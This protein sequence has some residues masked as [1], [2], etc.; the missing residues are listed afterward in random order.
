[1]SWLPGNGRNGMIK[2]D[3]CCQNSFHS[4]AS[5][6]RSLVSP[7]IKSPTIMAKS[8]FNMLISSIARSNTGHLSKPPP[9]LSPMIA[10]LNL[11]GSSEN[12]RSTIGIRSGK[13]GVCAVTVAI[14][15]RHKASNT[16]I[17]SKCADLGMSFSLCL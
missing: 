3:S 15:A 14:I 16:T 9:V 5:C 10:K 4:A 13:S 1:M 12:G 2:S 8:G 6:S 17:F 7:C 11:S